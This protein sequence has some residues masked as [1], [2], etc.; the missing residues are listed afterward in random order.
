MYGYIQY[1]TNV[2]V[3]Y[4]IRTPYQLS[5]SDPFLN[6][7]PLHSFPLGLSWLVPRLPSY[8]EVVSRVLF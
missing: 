2:Y 4:C 8:G 5:H 3:Q 1:N 6:S 7:P